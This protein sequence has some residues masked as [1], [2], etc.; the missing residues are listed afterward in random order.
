MRQISLH[1][2]ISAHNILHNSLQTSRPTYTSLWTPLG[3]QMAHGRYSKLQF[4]SIG[5]Q[6]DDTTT[7]ADDED[8]ET[9]RSQNHPPTTTRLTGL[10]TTITSLSAK[11]PSLS[12]RDPSVVLT[13]DYY[14]LA[15]TVGGNH[16]C[17]VLVTNR[18]RGVELRDPAVY[19]KR[20]YTRIPPDT[21]IPPESNAYCA[22][23]KP[24]IVV[25]GTSGVLSYEYARRD[26]RSKRFAVMWK[27]PYRL[28]QRD[29]NEVAMKWLDADLQD[30]ADTQQTH[31]TL[32]LYREM[33]SWKAGS[34][35][36][37]LVKGGHSHGHK[38]Q[39]GGGSGR[40]LH[41]VNAEDGA[42]LD[43]TFSGNCKAIIKVD[44]S[45]TPPGL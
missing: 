45:Y 22:F 19:T 37:D 11:D 12:A 6:E 3:T 31:T 43:A 44:F 41:T 13:R 20:G 23:R 32:D 8:D 15:L 9:S 28:V 26:G 35:S 21:K 38:R 30:D 14:G 36:G 29:G 16:S 18:S 7:S 10:P 1:M 24:S 25:Q 4:D 42:E 27:I 33:A 5:P 40:C 17:L 2:P 34:G 39:S